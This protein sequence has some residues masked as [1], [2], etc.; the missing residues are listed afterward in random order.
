M[1]LLPRIW[2]LE[3]WNWENNQAKLNQEGLK[4]KVEGDV[5]KRKIS[6]ESIM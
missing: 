3:R 1:L 2:I 6:S 5:T 4:E